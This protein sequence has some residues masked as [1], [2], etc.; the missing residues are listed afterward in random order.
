[1]TRCI[2]IF[3]NNKNE[4][5]ISAKEEI[6]SED[7]LFVEGIDDLESGGRRWEESIRATWAGSYEVHAH[8]LSGS[9]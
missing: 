3:I 2:D 8:R 7:I 1:M 9:D 4:K 6:Q 5:K